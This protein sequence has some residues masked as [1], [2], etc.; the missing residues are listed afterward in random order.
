MLAR[1][2]SQ[3]AFNAEAMSPL[4]H[5]GMRIS[6]ITNWAYGLTVIFTGLSGAAFLMAAQAS[7][8]ERAAVAQHLKFDVLAEDLAVASQ[9]LTAEARL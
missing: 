4:D 8:G 9:T 2:M 6:T 5:A 7:E 1:K 3:G